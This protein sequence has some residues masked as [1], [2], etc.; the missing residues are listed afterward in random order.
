MYRDGFVHDGTQIAVEGQMFHIDF[1]ALTGTPVI[2][3]C[4]TAMP[5][6]LYAPAKAR[7]RERSL[8]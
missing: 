5:R 6:D 1:K 4:Q 8:S 2:V 7:A 3:Y